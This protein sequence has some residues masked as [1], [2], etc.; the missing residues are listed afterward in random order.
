M[1]Y[2]TIHAMKARKLIYLLTL[3]TVM[4]AACHTDQRPTNLMD[5]EV[6]VDFLVD[7]HLIESYYA[8]QGGYRYD[9]LVPDMKASYQELY[10]KYGTNQEQFDRTAA[11]YQEHFD[12]YK[13]IYEQVIDKLSHYADSLPPAEPDEEPMEEEQP[14]VVMP[15]GLS[16]IQHTEN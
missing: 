13:A 3:L 7:A 1:L 12:E 8:L 14:R 10:A 2:P 6:F 4:T 5:E 15:V 9:S 11:Y 16:P